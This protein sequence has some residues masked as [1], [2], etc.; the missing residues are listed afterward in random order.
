MWYTN[1]SLQYFI[2]FGFIKKLRMSCFDA[3]QFD[4]NFFC[5]ILRNNNLENT[6]IFDVPI[7]LH[8]YNCSIIW[9]VLTSISNINSEVD[10]SKTSTANFPHKSVFPPDYKFRSGCRGDASHDCFFAERGYR[11]IPR[12]FYLITILSVCTIWSGMKYIRLIFT[13]LIYNEI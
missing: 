5:K 7:K 3:F 8:D 2:Q 13:W 10:I 1:A 11:N 12:L 9:P 4:S 6:S